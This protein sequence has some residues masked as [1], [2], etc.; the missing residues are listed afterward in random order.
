M[1]TCEFAAVLSTLTPAAV[2]G[3]SFVLKPNKNRTKY[4][5]KKNDFL[6]FSSSV[7]LHVFPMMHPKILIAID[8]NALVTIDVEPWCDPK[9]NYPNS[10]ACEK[11]EQE[12]FFCLRSPLHAKMPVPL[13]RCINMESWEIHFVSMHLI[14]LAMPRHAKTPSLLQCE[15]QRSNR[16]WEKRSLVLRA[17]DI[18]LIPWFRHENVWMFA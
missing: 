18:G 2:V 15:Q 6:Q 17:L 12:L 13:C 1:N 3:I 4:N 7:N 11:L 10:Y 5:V 9:T 8:I 16:S 14:R